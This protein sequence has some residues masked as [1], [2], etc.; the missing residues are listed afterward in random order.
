M[1]Q[2][3]AIRCNQVVLAARNPRKRSLCSVATQIPGSERGSLRASRRFRLNL[4]Q[5]LHR[6]E[7]NGFGECKKLDDVD[8]SFIA[9]NIGHVRLRPAQLI[10]DRSLR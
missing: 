7:T 3:K 9:L 1:E 8:A 10:R 4:P 2:R 5:R 6:V